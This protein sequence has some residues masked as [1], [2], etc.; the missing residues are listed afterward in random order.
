MK[1]GLLFFPSKA[2][3]LGGSKDSVS[4]RASQLSR[5]VEGMVLRAF[6]PFPSHS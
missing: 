3:S 1:R 2:V 4:L 5:Q 6:L